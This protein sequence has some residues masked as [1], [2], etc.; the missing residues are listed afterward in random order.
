MQSNFA[1]F[2]QMCIKIPTWHSRPSTKETHGNNENV[3]TLPIV[4]FVSRPY[5][6]YVSLPM[7]VAIQVVVAD[8]L[9]DSPS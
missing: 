5:V 2:E 9:S 7:A 1:L 6:L 3:F 4:P 8:H